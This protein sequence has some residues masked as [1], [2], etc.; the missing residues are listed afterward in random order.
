MRIAGLSQPAF[1]LAAILT[2]AGK[3]IRVVRWV[4]R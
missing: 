3:G 1:P 4:E 2:K